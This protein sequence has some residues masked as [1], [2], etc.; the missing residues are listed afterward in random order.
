MKNK[1]I[2]SEY[3]HGWNIFNLSLFIVGWILMYHSFFISNIIQTGFATFLL[4]I[5]S[6]SIYFQNKFE[7]EVGK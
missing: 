6:I 5:T 7:K 4:M 2:I 3:C 1:E